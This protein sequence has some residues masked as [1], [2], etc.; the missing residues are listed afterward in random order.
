MVLSSNVSEITV[1]IKLNRVGQG[2]EDEKKI[3]RH[4]KKPFVEGYS[5]Y[6]TPD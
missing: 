5:Y 1:T 4:L 2:Q 3:E 6:G